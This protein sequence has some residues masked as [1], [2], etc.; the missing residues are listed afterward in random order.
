MVSRFLSMEIN[1][2]IVDLQEACT[3]KNEKAIKRH[4]I[5]QVCEEAFSAET[6]F[7]TQYYLFIKYHIT[8]KFKTR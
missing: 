7:Y 4:D 3:R 2:N 8:K 6:R 1:I 5:Q